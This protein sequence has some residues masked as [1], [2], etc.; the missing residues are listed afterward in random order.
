MKKSF[1]AIQVLLLCVIADAQQGFTNSGNLRVHSGASISSSLDFTNSS[2]AVFVNNGSV[3]LQANLA[4]HESSMSA[5][6]GTLYLNGSSAQSVN[7]SAVMMTNNLVTNNSA[8]ITLNNDLSVAGVHTFTAGL[9]HSSATPNYLVYES[10]SSHTGA[11]DNRHATGWVKKI[12]STGFTFPVGDNTWLRTVAISNLSAASEF[13]AH[14]DTPAQNIYNL[15]SP[16]VQVR[17]NEYWQLDK[18]SGGT[19]QMTLNW[20]HSKVAMDQVFLTDIRTS[21]YTGGYWTNQGGSAT[22]NVTTTGS[23]SSN[24]ISSFGPVALAYTGFPIPLKLISFTGWRS[25]G[26][27]YLHWVSENEQNVSHFT[28]E[29]SFDG[30]TF[31][32]IGTVAARNRG[33]R[34]LYSFNDASSFTGTAYYRLKSI[35]TDGSYS[36]SRI[37]SMPETASQGSSFVVLNPVQ[38]AITIF[39]KS[40]AAGVYD[41]YLLNATGQLIQKG[42]VNMSNNGGSIIRL[43]LQIAKGIYTLELRKDQSRFSQ[44]L[45]IQQ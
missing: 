6:S 30:M 20:E 16:L 44:Q 43:P 31:T 24:A 3:Y 2:T 28:V 8:G 23:I 38:A 32:S 45:L 11:A 41:Y 27:S 29:R 35:D 40:A 33:I 39:N 12:G 21:R 10:G 25:T 34:E 15:F 22:G 37:I 14:Y 5:G 7:G 19:A 9:V 18:V 26:V 36:Y 13:N 4:N 17:V 1:L 42:V